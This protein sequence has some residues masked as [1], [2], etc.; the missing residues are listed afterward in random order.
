MSVPWWIAAATPIAAAGIAA[1]IFELLRT[2]PLVEAAGELDKALG[3]KD[4]LSS[5]LAS[6]PSARSRYATAF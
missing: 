2:K 3:L 4:R 1:L 6:R 5:A